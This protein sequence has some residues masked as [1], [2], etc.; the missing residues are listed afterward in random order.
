MNSSQNATQSGL[1]PECEP[2]SDT[3]MKRKWTEKRLR[4]VSDTTWQTQRSV[5]LR[6]VP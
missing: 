6:R 3:A 2:V 4:A 1:G 5:I